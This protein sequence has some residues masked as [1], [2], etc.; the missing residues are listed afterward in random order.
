[1]NGDIQMCQGLHGALCG[2]KLFCR[3]PHKTQ[4][5]TSICPSSVQTVE[6]LTTMQVKEHGYLQVFLRNFSIMQ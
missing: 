4:H 3:L 6:A 2:L 5:K 1:V